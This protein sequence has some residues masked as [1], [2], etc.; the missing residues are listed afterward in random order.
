MSL[1]YRLL[2]EH[3]QILKSKGYDEKSLN[4][5]DREGLLFKSLRYELSLAFKNSVLDTDRKEFTLNALGF[6]NDDKDMLVYKLY[7]SFDPEKNDLQLTK[8]RLSDTKLFREIPL[9]SCN[10]LPAAKD[11]LELI[12]ELIKEE[13]K[14]LRHRNAHYTAV[15]QS[16]AAQRH[17]RGI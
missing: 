8:L 14:A 9:K 12:G 15:H 5:P 16:E 7:Y 1:F 17:K 11:G 3:E 13:V 2:E 10:D 4:S 6:F